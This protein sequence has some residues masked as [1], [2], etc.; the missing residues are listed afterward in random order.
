[1]ESD[2]AHGQ[3]YIAIF[4]GTTTRPTFSSQSLQAE[5]SQCVST[6]AALRLDNVPTLSGYATSKAEYVSLFDPTSMIISTTFRSQSL[7]YYAI[8]QMIG[9]N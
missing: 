9:A 7:I 1:M 3:K 6:S 8:S 2:H 4:L 5:F